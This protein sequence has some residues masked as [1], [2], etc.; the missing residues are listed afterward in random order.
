V[1]SVAILASKGTAWPT[2]TVMPSGGAMILTSGALPHAA[3]PRYTRDTYQQAGPSCTT[4]SAAPLFRGLRCRFVQRTMFAFA[5]ADTN[6]SL[7]RD[8]GCGLPRPPPRGARGGR[9]WARHEGARRGRGGICRPAAD[10]AAQRPR[11][12]SQYR[13]WRRASVPQLTSDTEGTEPFAMHL[14]GEGLSPRG[15]GGG[16]GRCRRETA[17][18]GNGLAHR[19]PPLTQRAIACRPLRGLGA[20]RCQPRR[21]GIR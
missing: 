15:V 14:R 4:H 21:G 12:T 10:P 9:V 18:H 8:W 13:L 6:T 2:E 7:L 16:R 11:A 19:G 3:L 17:G 5:G 1:S 20:G